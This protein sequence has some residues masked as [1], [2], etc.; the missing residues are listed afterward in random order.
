MSVADG[1]L[2]AQHRQLAWER[3]LTVLAHSAEPLDLLHDLALR[4]TICLRSRKVV[5]LCDR[6]IELRLLLLV[7][8]RAVLSK[9]RVRA[10]N[11]DRGGEAIDA[12][13]LEELPGRV[14]AAHAAEGS[15]RGGD[16]H[17]NFALERVVHAALSTRRPGD[18]VDERWRGEPIVLW[19][20]HEESVGFL[21]L[22]PQSLRALRKGSLLDVL[23]ED[24]QLVVAQLHMADGCCR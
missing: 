4:T 2:V 21:Q 14:Q 9:G 3:Y 15:R 11:R 8:E 7:R 13:V 5:K 20:R 6:R 12:T 23:V 16:Y 10:P 22:R 24:G 1:A 18:R 19:R 17:A